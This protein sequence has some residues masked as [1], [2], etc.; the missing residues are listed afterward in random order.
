M[1]HLA[2]APHVHAML[3]NLAVVYNAQLSTLLGLFIPDERTI[4]LRPGMS[5]RME[6]CVLAHELGHYYFGHRGTSARNESA[7]NAYAATLL[8]DPDAVADA[9]RRFIRPDLERLAREAEVT[10]QIMERYLTWEKL[11]PTWRRNLRRDERA[12]GAFCL[13][14]ST[15]PPRAEPWSDAEPAELVAA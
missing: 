13:D 12:A 7:A 5:A 2:Y 11:M 15:M 4:L 10:P 6:R 1:S 9:R 3:L 14:W 8:V